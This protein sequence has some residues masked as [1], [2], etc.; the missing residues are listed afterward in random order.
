MPETEQTDITQTDITAEPKSV[1]GLK[2]VGNDYYN[3]I[4]KSPFNIKEAGHVGA[5]GSEVVDV[6]TEYYWIQ[7][8]PKGTGSVNIAPV[9]FLY[10]AEYKQKYGVTATNLF[11]NIYALG[12]AASNIGQ[13][14]GISN[15]YSTVSTG[16]KKSFEKVKE[17]IGTALDAVGGESL[18]SSISTGISTL[19]SP[20][21]DLAARGSSIIDAA[22]NGNGH[23]NTDLLSPYFFLYSLETTNKKYCF[24]LFTEGGS[25]WAVNNTFGDGGTQALLSKT[26]SNTLDALVGG[27]I[28]FASDIQD[29][30]N[31]MSGSSN[32]GFTMYNVEKAKAFSFPSGGKVISVRFPLFNTVKYGEWERN[33]RFI[34]LFGL[35]N[36]LFR[37]NNV[38]YYP[39]LFYD[40]STPGF[41]RMPLCYV[42]TFSVKPVGTTRIM[43]IKLNLLGNEDKETTVIVPEAWVVQI[44]FESLIADSANQY[45][46]SIIDLPITAN[47]EKIVVQ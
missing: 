18:K 42:K 7:N 33:Y 14:T 47:V 13:N 36:M 6:I 26:I 11:N 19:I 30:T 16:L 1:T 10:A 35:R 32:E 20:F 15:L 34:V 40:V 8:K 12:N 37:K 2:T 5:N 39:P 46:S 4:L 22:W 29:F 17:T 9:P 27:M 24:P 45:L 25:S 41:G 28:G 38:Q 44:D 23:L 3:Q 43:K 31:F 21:H